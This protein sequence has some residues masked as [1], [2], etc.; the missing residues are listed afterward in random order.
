LSE[1]TIRYS[2]ELLGFDDFFIACLTPERG[3]RF[4]IVLDRCHRERDDRA[5]KKYAANTESTTYVDHKTLQRLLI[6]FYQIPLTDQT[7]IMITTFISYFVL[8]T[9]LFRSIF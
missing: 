6:L 9:D 5:Q 2:E 4:L 7:E 8:L 1:W 3:D